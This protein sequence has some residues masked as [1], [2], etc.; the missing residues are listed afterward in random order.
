MQVRLQ[1]GAAPVWRANSWD[2][3]VFVFNFPLMTGENGIITYNPVLKRYFLP[4][5]SFLDANVSTPLAWHDS[6]YDVLNSRRTTKYH[7]RSQITI[8]EA[9]RPWGPWKLVWRDDDAE[10]TFGLVAPYTPTFPAKFI[11]P[12]GDMWLSISGNPGTRGY[13]L[14]YARVS[15]GRDK[16]AE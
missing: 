13:S 16:V 11:Q 6:I 8:F 9:E 10:R 15:F 7:R 1:G 4:N 3:A 5:Y 2:E 14:N 12:S